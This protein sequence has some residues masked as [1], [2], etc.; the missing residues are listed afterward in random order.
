MSSGVAE[1]I[2]RAHLE[3]RLEAGDKLVVKL[4][5]DP[6]GS[7][8]HL[9]HTVPLRKLREFARLGHKVILI[10]GDF[11]AQVGDPSARETERSTLSREQIETNMESYLSQVEPILGKPGQDFEVRHNSEWLGSLTPYQS[12]ELM[13]SATWQQLSSRADFKKR[14]ISGRPLT[15]LEMYYPLLQGY[16]SVAISADLEVGGTDQTYN[17]LMGRQVQPHYDQPPQDIMTFPLLVGT[18]GK[19]KMSKS[20]GNYISLSDGP[21][22]MYGKLMRVPDSLIDTYLELCTDLDSNQITGPPR[23]RKARLAHEIVHLYHGESAADLAAAE[24]TKVFRD[25]ELPEEIPEYVM[26]EPSQNILELL[27][28]TGLV[29][30]KSEARRLID[31]GGVKIDGAVIGD[32][33]T[34]ISGNAEGVLLQVGKRRFLRVKAP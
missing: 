23:D 34:S 19:K 22:E 10:I 4:G 3:R 7:E 12:A 32:Y 8:L 21:G 28:I 29:R 1:V 20:A 27:E 14:I 17:L 24:F 30:S 9:G 15:M 2:D 33:E 11:T 26:N 25:H 13:K 5:I 31:Q 16:D 18:D 6:T